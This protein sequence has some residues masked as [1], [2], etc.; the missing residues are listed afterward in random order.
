MVANFTEVHLKYMLETHIFSGAA[1]RGV[2]M[3]FFPNS[4]V[5]KMFIVRPRSTCASW[6]RKMWPALSLP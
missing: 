6:R 1:Y 5:S 3:F 4:V 2:A